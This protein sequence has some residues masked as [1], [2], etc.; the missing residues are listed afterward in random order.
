MQLL[1]VGK[2]SLCPSIKIFLLRFHLLKSAETLEVISGSK[3]SSE[4]P[5]KDQKEIYSCLNLPSLA[6]CTF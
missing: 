5:N 2:Q 4:S 1:S 6:H 3:Y